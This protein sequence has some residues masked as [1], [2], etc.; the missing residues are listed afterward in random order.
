[1][2]RVLRCHFNKVLLFEK[3]ASVLCRYLKLTI[4]DQSLFR[5]LFEKTYIEVIED[6]NI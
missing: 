4:F 2:M 6:F 3:K 1:M 5:C